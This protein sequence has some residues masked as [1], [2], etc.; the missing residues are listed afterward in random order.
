MRC[1]DSQLFAN[2]V[3]DRRIA[4]TR[5]RRRLAA[6]WA[7]ALD[8]VNVGSAGAYVSCTPKVSSTYRTRVPI[9]G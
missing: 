3:P 6:S 8:Y 7:V 4:L 1:H 9:L 5:L 2:P